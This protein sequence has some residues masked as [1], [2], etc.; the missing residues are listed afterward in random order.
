MKRSISVAAAII[1]GAAS[2]GLAPGEAHASGF[3]YVC[4]V[5]LSSPPSTLGTYGSFFVY[6]YTGPRCTGSFLEAPTYCSVGATDSATCDSI[7]YD[8]A[9]LLALYQNLVHAAASQQKVYEQSSTST[10]HVRGMYV[11]FYAD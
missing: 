5:A 2:V 7:L 4:A 8:E 3:G 11:N 1:V 6:Y 9:Q 10:W